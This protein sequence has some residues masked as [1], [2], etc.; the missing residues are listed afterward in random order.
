LASAT[1]GTQ[2]CGAHSHASGELTVDLLPAT[3]Q[4]GENPSA[5]YSHLSPAAALVAGCVDALLGLKL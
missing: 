2:R 4:R 3:H 5:L 1:A